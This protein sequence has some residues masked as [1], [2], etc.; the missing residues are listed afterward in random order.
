MSAILS[1][2]RARLS[3]PLTWIGIALFIVAVALIWL[4]RHDVLTV[5]G[6]VIGSAL[7]ATPDHRII[8]PI[9]A[10]LAPT[11][12]ATPQVEIPRSTPMSNTI[13]Q[14]LEAAALEGVKAAIAAIP[15]PVGVAAKAIIAVA[16]DRSP[17]NILAAIT[18]VAGAVEA[19][20][21]V[22]PPGYVPAPA[23]NADIVI[24]PQVEDGS[25][26]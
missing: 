4:F 13:V 24:Q 21:A 1:Y 23:A 10:L 3:E 15:G 6:T 5:L 17:A 2:L 12:P 18:D 14:T 19:A 25:N 7:A 26:A 11:R 8:N 20:L 16:E 9:R 22:V